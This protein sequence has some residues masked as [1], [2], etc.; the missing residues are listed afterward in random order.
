[1]AS[2]RVIQKKSVAGRSE[3]QRKTLLGLGLKRINQARVLEDTPAIRGMISKVEHLV[4][5]EA[6]DGTSAES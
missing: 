1:M 3:R 2:I 4:E 5:W 6:V